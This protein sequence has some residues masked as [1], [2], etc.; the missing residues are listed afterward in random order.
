MEFLPAF[1]NSLYTIRLEKFEDERGLFVRTF[2]KKE[3]MQINFDKEFVQ[4]N[5]S[6][7]K[8]KG[9]IRGI[10]F[11]YAPY[12]EYKLIRCIKGSVYDVA[13][14]LREKSPTFLQHF[15]IE[16]NEEILFAKFL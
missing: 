7:N 16:L 5:H 12:K 2:C 13:V 3:F 9:T 8:I 15:G 1:I 11:Q 4:F 14:D 6:Q 10:H